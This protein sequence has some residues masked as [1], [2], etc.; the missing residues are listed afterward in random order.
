[1]KNRYGVDVS[2]FR[3]ELIK[4]NESLENRPPEELHRYLLKLVEVASTN[5]QSAPCANGN[6]PA[7]WIDCGCTSVKYNKCGHWRDASVVKFE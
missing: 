6:C 4:L 2:Y 3:N 5:S 1:M 7:N